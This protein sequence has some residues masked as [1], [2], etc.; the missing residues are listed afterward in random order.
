MSRD[1]DKWRHTGPTGKALIQTLLAGTGMSSV[2]RLT[3][4][5][6][7]IQCLGRSMST[8]ERHYRKPLREEQP[9]RSCSLTRQFGENAGLYVRRSRLMQSQVDDEEPQSFWRLRRKRKH[10]IMEL[11]ATCCLHG[12]CCQSL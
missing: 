1:Q 2:S 12:H 8:N 11:G 5:A 3:Q 10:P 7:L 9:G 6:P 4:K